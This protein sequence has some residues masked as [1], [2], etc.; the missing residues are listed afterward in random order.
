MKKK[1]ETKSVTKKKI[2]IIASGAREH[3]LGWK[4]AQSPKVG[5]IYFAPGSPGTEQIGESTGIDMFDNE[6]LVKF[7]LKNNI[8]FTIAPQDDILANGVV[9]AFQAKDLKFL[10][11]QKKQH[12]LNGQKFFQNN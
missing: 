2:L 12:K 3:A 8:D 10:D 4:L 1:T 7:A 11:R 9:N 6:S 5:K